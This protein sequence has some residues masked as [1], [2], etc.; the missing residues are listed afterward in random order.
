[1]KYYSFFVS[2]LLGVSYGQAMEREIEF[3]F[4]SVGLIEADQSI[5]AHQSNTTEASLATTQLVGEVSTSVIYDPVWDQCPQVLE[6]LY[7]CSYLHPS[8]IPVSWFKDYLQHAYNLP[9]RVVELKYQEVL[10]Y[11]K[12][13]PLVQINE[14]Q[15]VISINTL[16]HETLGQWTDKEKRAGIAEHVLTLLYRQ[17]KK[18]DRMQVRT[19]P[20]ARQWS[21][22]ACYFLN[23]QHFACQNS[24]RYVEIANSLG[25]Y[26]YKVQGNYEEALKWFTGALEAYKEIHSAEP[27]PS[28][29]CCLT[30]IGNAFYKLGK[31]EEAK[32]FYQESFLVEQKIY[33][34]EAHPATAASLNRIG[35]ILRLEGTY[36]QALG[37]CNGS[38]KMKQKIYGDQPYS[39]VAAALNNV[40]SILYEQ[41]RY[42][43]ARDKYEKSLTMELKIHG[44]SPHPN[45]ACALS[46]MG[47]VLWSLDEYEKA[48]QYKREALSMNQ[49]IYSGL[50]HPHVADA[51]STVGIYLN[52]LGRCE[53]AL[54]HERDALKMRQELYGSMPHPDVAASFNNKGLILQSMGEYKA[55]M[56]SYDESLKIKRDLYGAKPHSAVA[57]SLNNKCSALRLMGNYEQALT[58]YQELLNIYKGIHGTQPHPYSAATLHY[59]GMVMQSLGRMKEA[60]EHANNA[61]LMKQELY[62]KSRS[63][64]VKYSIKQTECLIALIEERIVK[65]EDELSKQHDQEVEHYPIA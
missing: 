26:F 7:L 36:D 23:N 38:L 29:A 18:F 11:V 3:V 64:A 58:S 2:V 44:S 45:V 49:K 50:P 61:L 13:C 32:G 55:A 19:W 21:L 31:Y 53:E 17:G 4:P 33:G 57:T 48:L 35:V 52:K 43:E 39:G 42:D 40:G 59:I 14:Y 27:D 41:G 62:K 54:Q 63:R 24:A 56:E 28:V 47:T 30:N 25:H 65:Y 34:T 5:P 9:P 16:L 46:N 37:S 8:G 12:N 22:Y 20:A 15:Q 6:L 10:L 1:M 51:L 60:L